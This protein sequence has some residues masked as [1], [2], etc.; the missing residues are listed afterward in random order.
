[1][2]YDSLDEIE[3]DPDAVAAGA[4]AAQD[5]AT[6]APWFV[7][8]QAGPE[9]MNEALTTAAVKHYLRAAGLA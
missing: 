8:P 4:K 6:H 3:L 9:G 2:P 7:P 1:M 5:V